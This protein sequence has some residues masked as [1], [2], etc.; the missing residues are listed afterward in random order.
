MNENLYNFLVN[1]KYNT[2]IYSYDESDTKQG[3]ILPVLE[4][5]GWNTKLVDEIIPEYPVNG[6]RIDYKINAGNNDIFLKVKKTSENL[7]KHEQQLLDYSFRFGVEFSIL[8][9][10]L[11]WWFY[12]PMQKG[13][14]NERRFLDIDVTNQEISF[15]SN[16]FTNL[17]SKQKLISSEAILNAQKIVEDKIRK[18]NIELLMPKVWN[19]L[20]N[21]FN[22]PFIELFINELKKSSGYEPTYQ[23]VREY[24]FNNLNPKNVKKIQQEISIYKYFD[25]PSSISHILEVSW[26][27]YKYGYEYRKAVNIVA[28]QRDLV[29][30]TVMD[31]CTSVATI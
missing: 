23:E 9:N 18:K 30:T 27:Y 4:H 11:N 29:S 24:I 25:A 17:L 8:T 31:Q 3:I 20:M 22:S 16:N 21:D 13:K 1:I 12:L 6:F 15:V 5:L 19:S 10:G 2:A 7:E 28:H 26:Q 14:W